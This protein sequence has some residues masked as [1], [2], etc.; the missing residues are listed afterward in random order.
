MAQRGG[1]VATQIKFGKNIH[2]PVI[3]TAEAD[4]GSPR[5]QNVVMLGAI[6]R[7]L[8]VRMSCDAIRTVDG[9]EI[10]SSR[11][12]PR[13]RKLNIPIGE[14]VAFSGLFAGDAFSTLLP[15]RNTAEIE[16]SPIRLTLRTERTVLTSIAAV[17]EGA[18][19]ST[20]IFLGESGT[21]TD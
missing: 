15:V 4:M 2:S 3:G 1:S 14:N 9:E 6:I 17:R 10:I 19:L 8:A 11:V 16:I 5:A 20:S 13:L 7:S 18:G 21:A 12:P